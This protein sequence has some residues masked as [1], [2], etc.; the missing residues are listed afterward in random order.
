[1]LSD[2]LISLLALL[3]YFVPLLLGARHVLRVDNPRVWL[4][5]FLAAPLV[6]PMAYAAWPVGGPSK[7]RG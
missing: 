7:P 5:V 1:M 2:G 4:V 3:L 6:G